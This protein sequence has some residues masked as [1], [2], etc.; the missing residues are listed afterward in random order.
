MPA[1]RAP[2]LFASTTDPENSKSFY[3]E[4]LG[5]SLR[6]ETE[7]ALVFDAQGTQLRVQKVREHVA[8]PYT[9]IGWHV[10]D[11]EAA[12]RDL[13]ERGVQFERYSWFDQDEM[14]IW[15]TPGESPARVVWFKDPDD[16][17]LSLTQEPA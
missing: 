14:G 6:E 11:I 15:T 12:A 7:F 8:V 2:I 9:T 17:L 10:D 3:A 16:N 5:F 1:L 4:V 13:A